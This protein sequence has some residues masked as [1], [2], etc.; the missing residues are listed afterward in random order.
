MPTPIASVRLSIGVREVFL[1]L[2]DGATAD[3]AID[4]D[5][6]DI[7]HHQVINDAMISTRSFSSIMP[8]NLAKVHFVARSLDGIDVYDNDIVH[9]Q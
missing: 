8:E 7:V 3:R 9:H 5:D 6:D 1:N 2:H 4:V